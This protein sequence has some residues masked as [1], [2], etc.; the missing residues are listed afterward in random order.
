MS[1]I[2]GRAAFRATRPLRF[3][4]VAPL[5]AEAVAEKQASKD[6]LKQ[7][8]KKDPELYVLWTV[9][10]GAFGLAGWYFSRS[11]TTSTS[12]KSVPKVPGTEPWNTGSDGKYQYYPGGDSSQAPRDAPSA[13]NTVIIPNVNLP[14]ELH[15]KWNKY[16]KDGY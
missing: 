12:E 9:M 16:G 11:P 5:R 13:L 6:A 14:K 1:A 2:I 4:A 3:Q 10:A 7:A 8:G 15:E